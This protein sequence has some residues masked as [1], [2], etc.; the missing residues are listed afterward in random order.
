MEKG[1]RLVAENITIP[2][3]KTS[4]S[5]IRYALAGTLKVSREQGEWAAKTALQIL[6]GKSPKD[7]PIATNKQAKLYLNMPLAKKLNIRFPMEIIDN[8][9]FVEK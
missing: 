6:A 7:I 3:G 9:S 5:M 2:I 4:H 1:M 8:A